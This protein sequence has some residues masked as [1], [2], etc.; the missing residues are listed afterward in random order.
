SKR[1][2]DELVEQREHD[3]QDE[4]GPEAKANKLLL[5][6]QQGLRR[7]LLKLA[8]DIRCAPHRAQLASG[9]LMPLKNSQER[10][11]AEQADDVDGGELADAILPQLRHT[12]SLDTPSRD[13]IL[14]VLCASR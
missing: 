2:R 5:D 11:R 7:G 14:Y 1:C 4:A 13:R 9:G 8:A 3:Q 12:R 6:R 10:P